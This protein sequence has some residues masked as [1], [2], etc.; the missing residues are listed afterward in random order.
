MPAG[1]G[2]TWSHA[3]HLSYQ[4]SQIDKAKIVTVSLA[5][6]TDDCTGICMRNDAKLR[7]RESANDTHHA[8]GKMTGSRPGNIHQQRQRFLEVTAILAVQSTLGT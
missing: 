4:P 8:H 2:Q 6:S 3:R 7:E 1:C 5:F